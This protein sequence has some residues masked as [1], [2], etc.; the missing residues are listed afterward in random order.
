ME[1]DRILQ[2]EDAPVIPDCV[3]EYTEALHANSVPIVID[4][5]NMDI[6]PA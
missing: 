2:F 5:G 6:I 1:N 3:Q 4:N